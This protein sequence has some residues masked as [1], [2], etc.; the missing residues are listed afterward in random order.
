MDRTPAG[1]NG[2]KVLITG[3]G[4]YLGSKLA[5][6]I[7]PSGEQCF[8]ADTTFN[9]ISTALSAEFRNVHLV[10]ADITDPAGLKTICGEI[11]PQ[12][13]FHFAAS[14]DRTRDYSRFGEISEVNVKG[15]LNLLEALA[16]VD[17]EAFCYSGSSEVYGTRNP[18]PFRED[19]LPS[20]VSPYSLTKLMAEDLIRSWSALHSKPFTIFRIFLFMGPGMPPTTFLAQL[21]EAVVKREKFNMTGG[22]Q[23]RDYLLLEDLLY[24]IDTLSC[25][26]EAAGE[27]INLCSGTSFSMKEIAYTVREITGNGLRILN[28]LPYRENEIWDIRG[29]NEKL[30]RLLPGFEPGPFLK[31]IHTIF[32]I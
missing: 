22:L 14:I 18:V 17:Y 20:P 29:S 23:K 7:A 1:L 5:E 12:R 6:R 27:T 21:R 3:G 19:Q 4:G 15:T 25:T 8:L 32:K 26:E 10:R 13:V 9:G 24:C 30:K 16:D 2:K 31:G 28:T 11:A